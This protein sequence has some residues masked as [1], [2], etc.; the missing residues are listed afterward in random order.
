MTTFDQIAPKLSFNVDKSHIVDFDPKAN[1]TE[2]SGERGDSGQIGTYPAVLVTKQPD[3]IQC[4]L[5]CSSSRLVMKLKRFTVPTR[6]R[7]TQTGAKFSIDYD[8]T[9][10]PAK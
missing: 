9:A 10:M 7:I 5:P 8:V 1:V 3:N 6:L 2:F 4:W